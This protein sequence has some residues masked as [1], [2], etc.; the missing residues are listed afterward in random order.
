MRVP[1]VLYLIGGSLL[2]LIAGLLGSVLLP[3]L[4]QDQP[5]D[6]AVGY[7]PSEAR[8]RLTYIREGCD[9]CHTQQV[10]APEANQ[11]TVLLPGDIGAESV[12]GDYVYQSPV[13]WG[14]ERE[15][16][17]LSHVASRPYGKSK[18]WQILHLRDPRFVTPGSIMPSYAHLSD[19]DLSDL[20]DYLL[21]LK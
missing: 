18:G 12:P 20:A 16:P 1:S 9:Y 14:T 15:G 8:G 2:I 4:E 5:T 19:Q 6:I 21:T 10:R 11:G 17:D 13:L 7:S 3:S